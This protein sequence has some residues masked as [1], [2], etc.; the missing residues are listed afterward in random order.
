MSLL[1]VPKHETD[2]AH[3]ARRDRPFPSSRGTAA[4]QD[5]ASSEITELLADAQAGR[6]DAWDRIYALLYRDFHRIARAHTRRHGDHA[7][8]PTS[9]VS[10]AWLRLAG[11]AATAGSRRHLTCLVA[12]AMRYALLDEARQRLADKRGGD[13]VAVSL[14]DAA[15]IAAPL[16]QWLALDQALEHLAA[17]D[18]RL[19]RVVELRCFGGLS[20]AQIARLHE[21]DVRTVRR[22]WRRARAFLLRQL[23]DADLAI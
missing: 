11:S 1:S 6:S 18:A 4:G 12:R 14:E 5:I 13:G 21:M 20:E 7:F 23:G 3:P 16:T 17:L 8:S 9:L 2:A 10:E 19:G 15:A 22:D